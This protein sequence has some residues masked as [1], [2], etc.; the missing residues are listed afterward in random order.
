MTNIIRKFQ[1]IFANNAIN[2]GQFGSLQAT[3]KILSNDPEVLQNLTAYDNGW[4]DAAI[5]GEELPP[6]E[7]FQ[8][9]QFKTDY[10]LAYLLQ[11]GI[12]EWDILTDY[13]IGDIAR[14]VA[15]TILYKSLTND[16]IGN[17]LTDLTNWEPLIDLENASSSNAIINGNFDI[18]QQG[19][20]F[21]SISSGDYSA[22]QWKLTYDATTPT[23]D[24]NRT[25][26]TLGQ[27]DVPNNPEFY[28]NIDQTNAGSG[29]SFVTFAQPIEFVR[30]LSGGTVTISFYMK[31][32]SSSTIG[33]ELQQGFGTG[34]SPSSTVTTAAGNAVG[35]SSWQKFSFTVTL[36][37]ISGKTLGTNKDDALFLAFQLPVGV[38]EFDISQVQLENGS[39]ATNFRVESTAQIV[40]KCQRFLEK[41]YNLSDVPGTTV[42]TGSLYYISP[43]AISNTDIIDHTFSTY[44]R[45]P[46]IMTI[47]SPATGVSGKLRKI[48]GTAADRTG[49]T[50]SSEHGFRTGYTDVALAAGDAL[51]WHY[52]ADSR[53]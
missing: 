49:Y 48:T 15:G 51:R 26:F 5:S 35:T 43:L 1:K 19:G 14:N 37:S 40:Q 46:P 39:M 34:G 38:S 18:W 30:T 52:L 28:I 53:F 12:P 29:G 23:I 11:K 27:T 16:N 25:A 21:A 50:S 36:P 2:N 8:G 22:D 44:K 7:E 31:S 17:T 42:T 9:L 20:S 32:P 10:Q 13:H 6:L 45:T 3:T 4:N 47:Y 24:I 33:V 41:S